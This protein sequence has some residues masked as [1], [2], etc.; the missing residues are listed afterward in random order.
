MQQWRMALD[1]LTQ[2]SGVRD[3]GSTRGPEPDVSP[4]RPSQEEREHA[5]AI[6]D[7]ESPRDWRDEDPVEGL[8]PDGHAVGVEMA[9]YPADM[10]LLAGAPTTAPYMAREPADASPSSAPTPAMGGI[11]A[12]V[13][14]AGLAQGRESP[15]ATGVAATLMLV[16]EQGKL[17]RRVL[18][19]QVE[20]AAEQRSIHAAQARLLWR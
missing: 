11:G 9:E 4:R 19:A 7:E 13:G 8:S 5:Q 6:S 10:P 16:R 3:A 17:L 15:S 18:A 20:L 14:A 1:V 2:G 12:V